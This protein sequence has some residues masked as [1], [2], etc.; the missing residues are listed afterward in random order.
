MRESVKAIHWAHVDVSLGP[1]T[2]VTTSFG[3]QNSSKGALSYLS[4]G[5]R[6]PYQSRLGVGVLPEAAS[7]S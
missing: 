6:V 7:G 5:S 4:G 2:D 1:C 3:S